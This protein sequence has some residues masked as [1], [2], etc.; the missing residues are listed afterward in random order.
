[1]AGSED[2]GPSDENSEWSDFSRNNSAIDTFDNVHFGAK[3]QDHTSVINT[4]FTCFP[5]PSDF[6]S[7]DFFNGA[8]CANESRILDHVDPALKTYGEPL[9]WRGCETELKFSKALHLL[10]CDDRNHLLPGHLEEDSNSVPTR[11][12]D[13]H[14]FAEKFNSQLS[15]Q[16]LNS[17][18]NDLKEDRVLS[19][20]S[21]RLSNSDDSNSENEDEIFLVFR[22]KPNNRQSTF[23]EGQAAAGLSE[24]SNGELLDLKQE[25]A[26]YVKEYSDI[27]VEELTLREE[28]DREK[29]I[30]NNF[31]STLLAV[32]SK[33]RESQTGQGKGKKGSSAYSGKYLTTV[34][35]YDDCD[36]GPS[37]KVLLQLIEIMEALIADSPTVPGLLTE[38]ILKVLCAED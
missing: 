1:M 34:I 11:T 9:V 13:F 20:Q 15:C 7:A 37:N 22:G 19:N 10:P 28:L 14:K 5:L 33:I 16:T 4:L 6:Q 26:A 35:P 30:K 32:Q 31:I 36:G 3:S 29:E 24:L 38:Y 12:F 27:L 25:M 2:G 21:D 8:P 23:D 18:S 17:G